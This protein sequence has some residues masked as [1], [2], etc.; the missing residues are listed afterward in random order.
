MSVW[1]SIPPHASIAKIIGGESVQL[2]SLLRSSD[3][4]ETFQMRPSQLQGIVHAKIFLFAGLPFDE[5]LMK[6]FGSS[7]PDLL[8]VDLREGI[9][10]IKS[11]HEH[12]GHAVRDPHIWL[13]PKRLILQAQSIRDAFISADANNAANYNMNFD[14]LA[15]RLSALDQ[16][17]RG[18]L[19]RHKGR[20][21]YVYHPAFAY[22]ADAYGLHE[23]ALETYGHAPSPRQ[24]TRFINDARKQAITT[25]FTQ[26]QF[27][28][29]PVKVLA[30]AIGAKVIV[31]NPL[32]SDYFNN[33]K[34][35]T[36][37]SPMHI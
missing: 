6:K 35:I 10:F 3:S 21:F 23:E 12:D 31:L 30:E 8:L 25:V 37:P 16:E 14:E 20:S 34:R 32:S 33:L 18:Q 2:M 29:D 7:Y 13:D 1:A 36:T 5:V 22:F 9:P 17:I 11:G 28:A 4:P 26:P 15:E 27:R 24:I 19:K